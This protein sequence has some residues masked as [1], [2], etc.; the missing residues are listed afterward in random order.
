MLKNK[1]DKKIHAKFSARDENGLVH[2]KEC[3]L[4]VDMGNHQCK[5]NSHYNRHTRSWEWDLQ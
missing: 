3:P 2:C 5:A 4:V 1:R